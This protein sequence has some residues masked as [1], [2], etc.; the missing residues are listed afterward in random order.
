MK[1]PAADEWQFDGDNGDGQW[2][3]SLAV[4]HRFRHT[5]RM[6]LLPRSRRGTWLLAGAVG[7]VAG[8]WIG[9]LKGWQ[10]LAQ[11]GALG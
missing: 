1:M 4:R 9:S 2:P 8:D 6:P 11:D 5:D 7:L 10:N 3:L